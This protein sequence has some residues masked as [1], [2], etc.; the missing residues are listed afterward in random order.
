MSFAILS[1][2]AFALACASDEASLLQQR[3]VQNV[4]RRRKFQWRKRLAH[5]FKSC[6]D[7]DFGIQ[8]YAKSHKPLAPVKVEFLKGLCKLAGCAVVKG[9][10]C[11]EQTEL[12]C[13]CDAKCDS[14][15]VANGYCQ[16]DG[17]C[18]EHRPTDCQEPCP[19]LLCEEDCNERFGFIKDKNGCDTCECQCGPVCAIFCEFGNVPDAYGCPTC[20][21]KQAPCPQIRCSNDCGEDGYATDE[22]GCQTCE[23]NTEPQCG[24]V[25]AIFC[26]NGNIFKDGCPT[27]Q[28]QGPPC[29]VSDNDSLQT[30]PLGDC[31]DYD[32]PECA[33]PPF[34]CDWVNA[35]GSTSPSGQ[36]CCPTD[37]GELSCSGNILDDE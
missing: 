6:P 11:A 14:K 7:I 17:L 37:C 25:C 21:C 2:S 34:G 3:Q 32:L 10:T 31:A 27:C 26:E 1:V 8:F 4:A 19:L 15:R 13:P 20:Q 24:P 23:C 12:Q 29:D 35:K 30:I 9:E 16:A 33:R 28:C 36:S 5:K 22:N 18:G